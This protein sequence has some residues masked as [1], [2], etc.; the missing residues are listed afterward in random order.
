MTAYTERLIVGFIPCIQE[1]KFVFQSP[2]E[3]EKIDLLN[4]QPRNPEYMTFQFYDKKQKV[5][6]CH[7]ELTN[8]RNRLEVSYGTQ[9][10]FQNKGYMT[11]A[12][13]FS[14]KWVF[15]NTDE[16]TIWALPNG[17]I[18]KAVLRK[19]G[20]KDYEA[21]DFLPDMHWFRIEKDLA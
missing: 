2:I 7:I 14:V 12:L 10:E 21:C 20:F 6:I 19:C 17:D 3:D 18:S 9:E 11:E 16:K 5:N 13:E 15:D 8:K 4:L 1:G